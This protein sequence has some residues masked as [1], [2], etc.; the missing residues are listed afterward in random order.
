M[1]R[2][3]IWGNISFVVSILTL[4]ISFIV[5][6]LVG[7]VYTFGI[8]GMLHYTWIMWLFIPIGVASLI[9]GIYLKKHNEK[10]KKNVVIA[11]IIIPVLL[12]FGSFRF[13]FYS[14]VSYDDINDLK[15][16]ERQIEW[17]FPD[18][19]EIATLI[20]KNYSLAYVKIPDDD[21]NA[22]F[23]QSIKLDDKWTDEMPAAIK[24]M[25]P[26]NIMAETQ[27]CKWFMF[28]NQTLKQYN[29]APTISGDY[30]CLYLA[31][32]KEHS[33]IIVLFNSTLQINV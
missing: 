31:Y 5:V 26:W 18:N 14:S 11:V 6:C 8:A 10:Y 4:M 22:A 29:I 28:Y 13:A 27:D 23:E 3:K 2:L 20:E 21:N 16:I 32:D 24:G 12:V 1:N 30:E 9:I 15:K 19:V 7:D 25:L 17:N 33:R